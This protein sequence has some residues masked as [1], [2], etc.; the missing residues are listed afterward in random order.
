MC[1][2]HLLFSGFLLAAFLGIVL[3]TQ[4]KSTQTLT[5]LTSQ[6]SKSQCHYNLFLANYAAEGFGGAVVVVYADGVPMNGLEAVTYPTTLNK[7]GWMIPVAAGQVISLE[8]V[9]GDVVANGNQLWVTDQNGKTVYESKNTA[10][11]TITIGTASCECS[12]SQL[13]S[14]CAEFR[15]RNEWRSLSYCEQQN[16]INALVLIRTVNMTDGNNLYDLYITHHNDNSPKIIGKSEFLPWH[17]AYLMRMEN[18]IRS[19]GGNFTCLT[20]PYWDWSLDYS[21]ES[22]S[23][24]YAAFGG[25][26]EETCLVAPFD[27]WYD[28]V[29]ETCVYRRHSGWIKGIWAAS[30][31]PMYT[32]QSGVQLAVTVNSSYVFI[33]KFMVRN[34]HKSVHNYVGGALGSMSKL[35]SPADP[36]FWLH[37]ANVDRIWAMWQDCWDYDQPGMEYAQYADLSLEQDAGV[38]DN[39]VSVWPGV[40]VTARQI[41]DIH[42]LKVSYP[43]IYEA[44]PQLY[45][46]DEIY[47]PTYCKWDWFSPTDQLDK[48]IVHRP[49]VYT[50]YQRMRHFE[51][52][53]TYREALDVEEPEYYG[54]LVKRMTKEC[55]MGNGWQSDDFADMFNDQID[56]NQK[57]G[58]S[59]L[60]RHVCKLLGRNDLYRLF[61]Y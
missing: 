47:T 21:N 61:Y 6:T 14:E 13:S 9:A 36:L 56:L 44:W 3:A 53:S 11:G 42:A 28:P 20:I 7:A 49:E 19:M 1:A 51:T 4:P 34:P 52:V 43:P 59:Y 25:L 30:T 23:P 27:N 58:P 31:Y 5:Q 48:G 55:D 39:L 37:H 32:P 10:S 8:Y 40:N 45:G 22:L 15:T 41:L 16:F 35:S 33:F 24:L 46:R 54:A 50:D 26:S 12:Y 18:D 2:R 17:R 60:F 38:D 57:I 29:T